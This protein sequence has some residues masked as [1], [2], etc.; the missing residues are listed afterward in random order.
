MIHH[1]LGFALA[2]TELAIALGVIGTALG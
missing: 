2:T 1:A